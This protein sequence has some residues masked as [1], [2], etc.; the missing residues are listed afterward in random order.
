MNR[1][2]F[3][4]KSMITA[5]TVGLGSNVDMSSLRPVREKVNH[6]VVEP[7]LSQSIPLRFRQVHLDFHTSEHIPDI[8]ADFDADRFADTL[9]KAHVNSVTLFG[10]CH[11]GYI[12]HETDKFPERRHPYAQNP[13]LLEEQIEACH[14]RNIRT[15]IYVTVQWDDYTSRHHPEWLMRDAEGKPYAFGNSTFDPGF[16]EHLCINTPYI[17]FLKSYLD[18]LFEKVP[19]HGLFLDIHHIYP[20]ANEACIRGMQEK[21]LDASKTEVRYAYYS[22]VMKNYKEDLAAYIRQKDKDCA[23]FFNGGHVGPE[24]RNGLDAYTHLELESLPSGGWGYLHFPLT[25]RYARTLGKE[26]MGMT[27]KFHT[28]W[29]DFHSLKNRAALEFECFTMLAM[30][31]KCSIGDQLH[32]RGVMD[33][34]TYELIGKVYEQVAEKEAWCENATALTD[35]GLLSTEEFAFKETDEDTSQRTPVPM[36]GAIRML[37]EGKQQFDILD[38]KSDFTS[39]KVL[40]LPDEIP[41]DQSLKAKL[42]DYVRQ[43]GALIASYHSGL[44]PD[45]TDF[46]SDIF[47]LQLKGEA[48]YSPDF[49][50][51]DGSG[52]GAGLPETELVMYQKGMEVATNDARPLLMANVPYFNRTWEHFSSHRHTPSAGKEGYPAVTQKGK[53]IYFM[54]P[55][56]TQYAA[57]APRWCREVFL[58]AMNTL[59]PEPL[60]KTQGAPTSTIASINRQAHQ[61]RLVL[62]L[63]NYIPER[64]GNDFDTVE[65]VLPVRGISLSLNVPDKI[66]KVTLVPQGEV[67]NFREN[68]GRLAFDLPEI[69][70]HQM[71]ELKIS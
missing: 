3:L 48:P 47:G 49:L 1:R 20:N 4:Q 18:E 2:N 61:S 31:A 41:I 60:I 16:Y 24:I 54:H 23:I 37:Q 25:S 40:V 67:L 56:F 42:E 9:K 26:V 70:G 68:G 57:N 34:A 45:H 8:G 6:Q 15:P 62:H 53:V 65:D 46:A 32:P 19:V 64:R 44:S 7:P 35:I 43:G 58:N 50:K 51:L 13:R 69:K 28:A 66:S 59:L 22:E 17:D 52:I 27:G 29:G 21:G 14:K 39:Y 71:V 63:L 12:Y 33:E 11:H 38:S 36:M 30:N 55:L 10:R 5:G